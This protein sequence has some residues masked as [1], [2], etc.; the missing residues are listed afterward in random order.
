[1]AMESNFPRPEIEC[2]LAS[3]H[4]GLAQRR[5][6]ARLLSSKARLFVWFSDD[7]WLAVIVLLVVLFVFSLI[8]FVGVSR[9]HGVADVAKLQSVGNLQTG[10]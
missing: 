8:I 3:T 2:S 5:A 6:I 4:P 1:M 9:W 7:R 10:A